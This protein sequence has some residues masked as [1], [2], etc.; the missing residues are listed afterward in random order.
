[1][2]ILINNGLRKVSNAIDIYVQLQYN[3]K[4]LIVIG[5]VKEQI[6]DFQAST[7]IQLIKTIPSDSIVRH[8]IKVS[9]KIKMFVLKFLNSIENVTFTFIIIRYVGS[10]QR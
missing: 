6:N 1:M 5:Q 2:I 3:P 4:N 10:Q 9:K 7:Q 8:I